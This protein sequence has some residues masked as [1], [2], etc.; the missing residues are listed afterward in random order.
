V[1][2]RLIDAHERDIERALAER[3]IVRSWPMRGTLHFLAASDARWVISLLALRALAK[4]VARL[5]ALGI[6]DDVVANARRA[7]VKNLEGGR[8]LTRPAAYKVLEQA[9]VET[10]GQRGLHVLWRLAHEGLLCFGSCQGKQQTFALL[11]E[12]LPNARGLRREEALPELAR[13]YFTRHGPATL[14]DFAWWSGMTLTEARL[15][16]D[17]AGSLIEQDVVDG[18]RYW[19]A[20]SAGGTSSGCEVERAHV[21]P[22]FDEF[23]VGYADRSAALVGL[24]RSVNP[25][26]IHLALG[27]YA[28]FVD[29]KGAVTQPR[30]RP[31]R[32]SRSVPGRPG[33]T[34]PHR[35]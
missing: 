27:R 25:F 24:T 29:L 33:E 10:A 26:E 23:F 31:K 20:D 12:W 18:Q 5:K 28:R 17:M 6:D 8:L 9:R 2:L 19:F 34:T 32:S 1:G 15:A 30:A 35:R 16:T 14:R 3:T 21:L 4:A 11:E 22:A 13:R 7:L